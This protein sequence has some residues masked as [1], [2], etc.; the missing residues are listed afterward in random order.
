MD[1][2]MGIAIV[3]GIVLIVLVITTLKNIFKTLVSI[4]LILVVLS[5]LFMFFLVKDV[6]DFGQGINNNGN[7]Y[8]LKEGDEVLTGFR[9]EGIN[10]SNAASFSGKELDRFTK[11]M[12][13]QKLDSI[14]D[15]DYKIFIIDQS[16][17]NDTNSLDPDSVIEYL[18]S[19]ESEYEP[20]ES[21][22]D[23]K[24]FAFSMLVIFN[25]KND[26]LYLF[27]EFK[28]NNLIIYPETFMFKVL[29]FTMKE[30]NEE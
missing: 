1:Y 20:S 25:L 17:F 3:I 22:M 9:M 8:L 15:K 7:I 13:D 4:F 28:N 16:A 19:K 2:L 27:K 29:K 5:A 21:T 6:R 12:E 24:A 10:L 23:P 14:L 18:K 30:K 26:P 11:D